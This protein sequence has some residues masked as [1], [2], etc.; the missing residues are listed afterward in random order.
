MKNMIRR[1]ICILL[2]AVML[3]TLIPA[4]IIEAS[5]E[6]TNSLVWDSASKYFNVT[7]MKGARGANAEKKGDY[8][9]YT[10]TNATPEQ[11]NIIQPASF[12]GG[13]YPILAIRY[14]YDK[15][16]TNAGLS[17]GY[18]ESGKTLRTKDG[19][20]STYADGNW[21]NRIIN[22]ST[23]DKDTSAYDWSTANTNYFLVFPFGWNSCEG[24]QFDIAYIGLF[25]SVEDAQEY[26]GESV[27]A[28]GELK[29]AM[30]GATA[31][32]V[33][34]T[35]EDN[36]VKA[37][38]VTTV[39]NAEQ[40][41][42]K[43][44]E[45]VDGG[46]YPFM[47][48]KYKYDKAYENAKLSLSRTNFDAV[49]KD[50]ATAKASNRSA[51][52][53]IATF[54]DGEWQIAILDMRTI[55]FESKKDFPAIGGKT[56]ADYTYNTFTFLPFGWNA[57]Q[58][59]VFSLEYFGFFSTEEKAVSY[60]KNMEQVPSVTVSEGVKSIAQY[61][62]NGTFANKINVTWADSTFDRVV[63]KNADG[64]ILG[65][66]T[67]ASKTATFDVEADGEY[68][69]VGEN[70]SKTYFRGWQPGTD[71]ASI[72]FVASLDDL[73]CTGAGMEITAVAGDVT[74]NFGMDASGI[75]KIVYA[76][77]MGGGMNYTAADLATSYIHVAVVE[78]LP[79]GVELTFTVKP[80][81]MVE[82]ERI[83]GGETTVVYTVSSGN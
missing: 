70:T 28:G 76:S 15:E 36:C 25:K 73:T 63:L 68:S 81:K 64:D 21:H 9:S 40:I 14:R 55:Q 45:A 5:A 58:D 7:Y 26:I 77:I 37:T 13:D 32:T 6:E 59:S 69:V 1:P 71:G 46:K 30:D 48:I 60:V 78:G 19:A 54:S 29:A 39:Q 18:V 4:G 22:L 11:L 74:K 12:V 47:A 57:V 83:Y 62:E 65:Y 51:D 38:G 16:Y 53:Q 2:V 82:G 35:F 17:I 43:M 61:H 41:K 33:T 67:D 80:F 31:S 56:W 50:G 75:T 8:I 72:R 66:S 23:I 27:L 52:G 24:S 49:N 42:F 10:G 44:P 20:I 3:L 34:V 79:T